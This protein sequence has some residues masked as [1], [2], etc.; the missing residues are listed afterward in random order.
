[1]EYV[2]IIDQVYGTDQRLV[3]AGDRFHVEPKDVE[4]L[5]KMGCI[6][7]PK[8]QGYKTRDMSAAR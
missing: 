5:L 8:K 3:R 1:M 6:A 7:V 4:I 2:A